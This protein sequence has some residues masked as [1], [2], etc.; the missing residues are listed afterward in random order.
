MG[1]IKNKQQDRRVKPSCIN[2]HIKYKWFKHPIKKQVFLDQIQ[3]KTQLYTPFKKHI[4]NTPY[5]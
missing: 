4:V 3:N 1:H 5:V 2:N